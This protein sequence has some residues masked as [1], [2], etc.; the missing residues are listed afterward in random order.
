MN[1]VS[2]DVNFHDEATV[3]RLEGIKCDLETEEFEAP[4][5]D[6]DHDDDSSPSD[7]Q[8]ENLAEHAELPAI[9][10]PIE[11]V[12]EPPTNRSSTWCR[13]V[14]RDVENHGAPMGTSRECKNPDRYSRYVALMRNISD[15][16][17][18]SYEEVT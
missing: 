5:S 4:T 14:L 18:S 13:D 2:Q 12:D 3:K 9:D 17:P 16:N 7:V 6:S 1:E 15:S 8:R 11:L 10:E